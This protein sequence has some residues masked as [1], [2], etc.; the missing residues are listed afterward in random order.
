MGFGYCTAVCI[1][2]K[3]LLVHFFYECYHSFCIFSFYWEYALNVN[4]DEVVYV[5]C[6]QAS[7]S[8]GTIIL[9][10]QDGVQRPPIHFP[11]G[12]HLLSFL[13][14]LENGLLPHGQLDPPL[15][16]QRG[17]GN[18]CQIE[19]LYMSCFGRGSSDFI[20]GKVLPKLRRRSRGSIGGKA[21]VD[22]EST[23]YVFRIARK[24]QR[25]DIR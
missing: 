16:S 25:E 13:S 24:V 11:K 19:Y 6:H 7:D 15:W 9:V 10:G 1:F 21:E 22:D 4:I 17:K 12:G 23:D 3:V 18:F 8:G 20:S 2:V 5:H 14:C